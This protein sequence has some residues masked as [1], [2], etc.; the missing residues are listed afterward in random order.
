MPPL[1]F[2][3]FPAFARYTAT[4]TKNYYKIQRLETLEASL[5]TAMRS[6][7]I[8]VT[9]GGVSMGE[10]DLLKPTIERALGGTIH[11]GRVAMK[12]GKPTTFATIPF[13]S[14]TGDRSTCRM[15]FSLPG[16]PASA[17]VALHLFVLQ[18]LHHSS[19]VNPPQLPRVNVILLQQLAPDPYR[20]EYRRGIVSVG[21]DGKLYAAATSGVQRSSAVGSFRSANALLVLPP[22]T[23]KLEKGSQVEALLLGQVA[24]GRP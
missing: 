18:S 6:V 13:K 7:D 17:V 23:T 12:P 14:N 24:I 4:N 15:I 11:F 16:N 21:Q 5:R 9:T 2:I 8:I 19:G 20:E 10:L 1:L 3:R 22:G